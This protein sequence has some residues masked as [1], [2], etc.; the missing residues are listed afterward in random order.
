MLEF[1]SL[2]AR[3]RSRV[4]VNRLPF[5]AAVLL[6]WIA[7]PIGSSL[8][9]GIYA[10]ATGMLVSAAL[11]GCLRPARSW[12]E[13]LGQAPVAVAVLAAVAAAP[14]RWRQHVRRRDPHPDRRLLYGAARQPA[15]A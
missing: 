14:G 5:L 6:A 15:P 9:W 3:D 1:V 7:V 13:T 12:N 10:V 11:L 8:H 4:V 2:E